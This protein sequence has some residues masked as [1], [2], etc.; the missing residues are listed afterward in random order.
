MSEVIFEI[1]EDE[2]DGDYR[3]SALDIG[4]HTEAETIEELRLNVKEAV[5][6]YYDDSM[7][8]PKLIRLHFIRDE[9]LAR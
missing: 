3:A 4:I 5:D 7:E 2:I 6:C 9:I 8:A 1:R